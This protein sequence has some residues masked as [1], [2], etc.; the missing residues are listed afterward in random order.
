MRDDGERREHCRSLAIA[1]HVSEHVQFADHEEPVATTRAGYLELG[2]EARP[3]LDAIREKCFD[4]S[5]ASWREVKLC[6]S[7]AC[8]LYPFRLGSNPWRREP[9]DEQREAASRRMIA[10]R[11]RPNPIGGNGGDGSAGTEVPE[12]ELEGEFA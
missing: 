8:A 9:S 11:N 6:R 5:G 1:H 7:T 10:V 2:H 4:C 12:T 3:V